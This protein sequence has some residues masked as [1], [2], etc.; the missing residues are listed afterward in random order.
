ML[1]IGKLVNCK[2]FQNR[3]Y[4]GTNK[5]FTCRKEKDGMTKSSSCHLWTA[6]HA[7]SISATHRGRPAWSY[8][9]PAGACPNKH[10]ENPGKLA[11]LQ[12]YVSVLV[13]SLVCRA[14]T[15]ISWAEGIIS[16][17]SPCSKSAVVLITA[18][19]MGRVMWK[20]EGRDIGI[21]HTWASG[22]RSCGPSNLCTLAVLTFPMAFLLLLAV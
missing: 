14:N 12:L 2:T 5:R 6:R 16:I 20:R 19:S 17:W 7:I 21:S 15:M 18:P 1:K 4:D 13:P 8:S 9:R 10:K 3:K 11:K 22:H